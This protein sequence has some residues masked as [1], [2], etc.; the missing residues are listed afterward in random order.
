MNYP[1]LWLST[2]SMAHPVVQ[3]SLVASALARADCTSEV[4]TDALPGSSSV[5]VR[6]A[7]WN[8]QRFSCKV[9]LFYQGLAWIQNWPLRHNFG[10]RLGFWSRLMTHCFG[11]NEP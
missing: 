7:F 10:G 9:I 6:V 2:R 11:T 3:M 1:S 5:G 4:P 8:M